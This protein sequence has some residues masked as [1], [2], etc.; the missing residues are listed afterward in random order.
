MNRLALIAGILCLVVAAVV[1]VFAEGMRRWYS[2]IF[3]AVI[4][5]VTLI[6]ALRARR[7]AQ[8]GAGGRDATGDHQP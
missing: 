5:A 4:G 2:G 8:P 6:Q 3:F 7:A 1:F